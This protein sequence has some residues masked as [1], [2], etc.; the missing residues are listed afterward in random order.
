MDHRFGLCVWAWLLR[1]INLCRVLG[2]TGLDFIYSDLLLNLGLNPG[3]GQPIRVN[4]P[5]PAV[6]HGIR[7]VMGDFQNNC[8]GYYLQSYFMCNL[9]FLGSLCMRGSRQWL[10]RLLDSCSREP[11]HWFPHLL[12]LIFFLL[13]PFAFPYFIL[14]EISG[15]NERWSGGVPKGLSEGDGSQDI[16]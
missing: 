15:E 4:C 13:S 14:R 7:V 2:R 10:R 5:K 9:P 11:S 8:F 16:F 6:P 12:L 1:P 3:L